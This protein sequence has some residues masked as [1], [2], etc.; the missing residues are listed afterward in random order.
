[1]EF[2]TLLCRVIGDDRTFGTA[3]VCLTKAKI[4]RCIWKRIFCFEQGHCSTIH[5]GSFY[6][7]RATA[8]G[9]QSNAVFA[10]YLCN[11]GQGSA[12]YLIGQRGPPYDK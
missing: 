3:C 8:T 9:E 5:A 11:S 4:Y 7:R 12:F 10:R 2:I 1:M 6:T